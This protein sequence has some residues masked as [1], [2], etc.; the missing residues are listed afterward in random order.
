M[1]SGCAVLPYEPTWK[2]SPTCREAFPSCLIYSHWKS[3]PTLPWISVQHDQTHKEGC[4]SVQW[5]FTVLPLSTSTRTFS[6]CQTATEK[7]YCG[8]PGTVTERSSQELT[9]LIANHTN[10]ETFLILSLGGMRN[11]CLYLGNLSDHIWVT[12]NQL[13][14]FVH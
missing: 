1:T 6:K 11:S 2:W 8:Y 14:T 4:C 12:K 7:V 9:L 10:R 13:L 3:P 5:Y